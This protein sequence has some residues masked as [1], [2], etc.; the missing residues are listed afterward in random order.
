MSENVSTMKHGETNDWADL[1]SNFPS[2]GVG[3]QK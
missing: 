3:M 1:Q 2:P